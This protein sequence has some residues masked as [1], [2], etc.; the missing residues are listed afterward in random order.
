MMTKFRF[1]FL[2]TLTSPMLLTSLSTVWPV[3]AKLGNLPMHLHN[4]NSAYAGSTM[5]GY[6]P[7]EST[8]PAN[9]Q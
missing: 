6:L 5:I 4:Q 7:K 8:G 3:V 1:P 9:N 2:S